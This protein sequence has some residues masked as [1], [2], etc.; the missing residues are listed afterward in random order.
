M[1]DRIKPWFAW[2]AFQADYSFL[3]F[4]GENSNGMRAGTGIV[5]R[6]GS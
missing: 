3:R 5:F 1:D 6:F 2:R 4:E